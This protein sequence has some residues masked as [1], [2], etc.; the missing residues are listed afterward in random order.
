M[1]YE[2]TDEELKIIE[3][4]RKDVKFY[5]DR[6]AKRKACSH[7]WVNTDSAYGENRYECFKCGEVEWR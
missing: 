3:E 6:A 1:L 4:H 5:A 7:D 2:L